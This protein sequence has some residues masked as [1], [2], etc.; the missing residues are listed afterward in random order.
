M[1]FPRRLLLLALVPILW[2]GCATTTE[3]AGLGV[4]LVNVRLAEATVLE[5]TAYFT[6]RF[7]NETPEPLTVSGGVFKIYLE[8]SFIGEG[9]MGDTLRVERF[10]SGTLEVKSYLRNL[11]MATRVRRIIQLQGAGYR[12][13]GTIYLQE[14]N[15]RLRVAHEGALGLKDFQP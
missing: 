1:K 14:G 4:N 8:G 13:K 11:S 7:I 2:T 6:V 10:N 15:R 5:T 3:K 9:V 12:V